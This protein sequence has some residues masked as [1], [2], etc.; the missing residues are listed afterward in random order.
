MNKMPLDDDQAPME[1]GAI[2][3]RNVQVFSPLQNLFHIKIATAC[4]LQI[5]CQTQRLKSFAVKSLKLQKKK[6]VE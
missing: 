5:N 6:G 3:T 2:R 4:L 1:V